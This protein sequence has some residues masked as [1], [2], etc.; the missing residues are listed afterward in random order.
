VGAVG[1]LLQ[2]MCAPQFVMVRNEIREGG[3]GG[4]GL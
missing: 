2:F 4:E 1:A 3:G